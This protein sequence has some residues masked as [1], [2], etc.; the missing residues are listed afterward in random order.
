[1][2]S[3]VAAA[4]AFACVAAP[5][6]AQMSSLADLDRD[7]LRIVE[8][9]APAVVQVEPGISGVC[10][11]E[12]GYILTDGLVAKAFAK[13]KTGTVKVTFADQQT[14]D[15]R[16]LATDAPTRT[17]VLA[18]DTRR[19]LPSVVPGDPGTLEVGNFLLT[20]GNAF[21][22]A[23]ESEPSVTLGVVSAVQEQGL[24]VHHVLEGEHGV[25]GGTELEDALSHRLDRGDVHGVEIRLHGTAQVEKV[26]DRLG[27]LLIRNAI[28]ELQTSDL[29]L[30]RV[31]HR[32]PGRDL[33][34]H[35]H[36][37]DLGG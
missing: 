5:A 15:A 1:M 12:D 31:G 22:L 19:R 28:E 13:S 37:L 23:E 16:L 32:D 11:S 2:R 20:V 9:V 36:R 27:A 8:Q 30:E 25:V 34:G 10:I 35:L 18:I 29:C 6:A 4:F 17:V 26:V 24:R 14:F 21:G 3:L 7:F 33:R